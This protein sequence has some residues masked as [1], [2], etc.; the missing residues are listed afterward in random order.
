MRGPVQQYQVHARSPVRQLKVATAD[1]HQRA[2]QHVRIHL[3]GRALADAALGDPTAYAEAVQ[4]AR[5]TFRRLIAW[6]EEV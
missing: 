1:L 5:D 3:R 6:L 2:E 4:G